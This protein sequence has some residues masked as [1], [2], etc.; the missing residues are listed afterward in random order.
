[1]S[2][3]TSLEK[4]LQQLVNAQSTI[5][6]STCI[7]ED[8]DHLR[9]RYAYLALVFTAGQGMAV[10]WFA[11]ADECQWKGV[12]CSGAKISKIDLV[13]KGL[14][15]TIPVDVGLWYD[16]TYFRV[17]FNALTGSL[18][19]SIGRWTGL[20]HF[21]LGYNALRGSLPSSIGE[22]TGLTYFNVASNQLGGSL[23]SSIGKWNDLIYF[24]VR[25]NQ[26]G[27]PL[28]SSIGAWTGLNEIYLRDNQ[29][30]GTVPK[31]V[32]SWTAIQTV[33][34]ND[35]S[36]NGI[37]PQLG[38]TFCPKNTSIGVF[39]SDCSPFANSPPEI[40]CKCCSRCCAA[41]FCFANNL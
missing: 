8:R 17:F 14:T 1:M 6:L 35:N 34:F 15:G 23:D 16:L 22:W 18:P 37:M 38:S 26:M 28:P 11:D 30:T 27:G 39:Y 24:N 12:G 25:S 31:N 29:F 4:A 19:S 9:Q 40:I 3:S 33:Y 5:L 32:S 20:T 13:N 21:N 2:G 10:D 36:F 41:S 7:I